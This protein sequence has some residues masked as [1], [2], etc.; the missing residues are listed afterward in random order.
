[1]NKSSFRLVCDFDVQTYRCGVKAGNSLR[2]RRDIE[3]KDHAGKPTGKVFR[4]GGVWKVLPGAKDDIGTVRLMQPD[5][6]LHTWDD[7][8]TLLQMFEIVPGNN[9]MSGG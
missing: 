3:I 1:M 4:E 9:P 6:K 8:L 7:D 2:L 5:G